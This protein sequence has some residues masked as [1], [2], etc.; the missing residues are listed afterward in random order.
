[1]YREIY[2]KKLAHK[3]VGSRKIWRTRKEFDLAVSN[4]KDCEGR[5][6]S[7]LGETQS[8]SLKSFS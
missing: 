7:S 4:L 3:T 2:F 5:I 8:F 1:M 6:P